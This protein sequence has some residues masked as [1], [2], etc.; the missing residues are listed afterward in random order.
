VGERRGR[1]NGTFRS[2]PRAAGRTRAHVP[3]VNGARVQIP[4]FRKAST[5]Q[6]SSSHC[7][8]GQVSGSG[9]RSGKRAN[10]VRSCRVDLERGA[11]TA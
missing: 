4:R 9:R 10:E 5:A 6:S 11:G 3:A 2:P 1:V 8:S 7:T